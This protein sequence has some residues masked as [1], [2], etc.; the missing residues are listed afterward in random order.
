MV[1]VKVILAFLYCLYC[2]VVIVTVISVYDSH[3]MTVIV[4]HCDIICA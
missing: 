3:C 1:I 4:G 2:S